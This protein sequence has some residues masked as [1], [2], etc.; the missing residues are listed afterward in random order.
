MLFLLYFVWLKLLPSTRL[1]EVRVKDF[2]AGNKATSKSRI[3]FLK[4]LCGLPKFKA[5]V[6]LVPPMVR[7][8]L[9]HIC[10][11]PNYLDC[12]QKLQPFRPI[13]LHGFLGLAKRLIYPSNSILL[14]P[15]KRLCQSCESLY[16]TQ[17]FL[18]ME[19]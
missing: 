8:F 3:T 11:I 2:P 18:W 12:S 10:G 17:R 19:G 15:S 16:W 6:D 13:T 7:M 5:L 9:A 14:V 4:S 1:A